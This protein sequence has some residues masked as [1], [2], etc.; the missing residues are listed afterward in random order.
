MHT[1]TVAAVFTCTHCSTVPEQVVDGKATI[2]IVRHQLGCPTLL[3]RTR[4]RWPRAG[5]LN[6][7]EFDR[8]DPFG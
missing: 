1:D 7:E 5:A 2:A 6:A 8:L 4:T 3:A